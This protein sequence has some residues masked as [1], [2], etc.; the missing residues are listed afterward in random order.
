MTKEVRKIVKD[1]RAA[2]NKHM[3][4]HKISQKELAAA[5]GVHYSYVSRALRNNNISLITMEKIADVLDL[6][7][8]LKVSLKYDFK[9]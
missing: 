7:I 8:E 4:K 6:K 1:Y 2:I 5:L 9:D 3:D